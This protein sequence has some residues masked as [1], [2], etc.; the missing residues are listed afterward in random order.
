MGQPARRV[1]QER[2][3]SAQRVRDL[4]AVA[5]LSPGDPLLHGIILPG[6]RRPAAVA[7]TARRR[8]TPGTMSLWLTTRPIRPV[9]SPSAMCAGGRSL[10]RAPRNT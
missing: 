3:L 6:N 1:D 7:G 4:R 2:P 5:Q 10:C 8:R 9:R